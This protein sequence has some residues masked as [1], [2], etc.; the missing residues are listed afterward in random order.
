MNVDLRE[1]PKIQGGEFLTP[2]NAGAP[3]RLTS[4]FGEAIWWVPD[5]LNA[6]VHEL[7]KRPTFAVASSRIG[8][9]P[10]RRPAWF[11]M[12]ERAIEET[13]RQRGVMISVNE[14]AAAT[15]VRHACR[16]FRCET[17]AFDVCS[18]NVSFTDWTASLHKSARD[19]IHVSPPLSGA[20]RQ[21]DQPRR[22]AFAIFVSDRLYIPLVSKNGNISKLVRSRLASDLSAPASVW[23]AIT[24]ENKIAGNLIDLGAVGWMVKTVDGVEASHVESLACDNIFTIEELLQQRDECSAEEDWPYLIHCTRER[25]GAWPSQSET[26]F[27]DEMLLSGKP[28]TR[29]PLASLQRIVDREVIDASQVVTRKDASAVCCFTE[30]PLSEALK[31]RVFR[32]HLQ[33]WDSEPYGVAIHKRLLESMGCRAVIYGDEA[34]YASLNHTERPFFQSEGSAVDWTAEREWRVEGSVSL[35]DIPVENAFV[36][37]PS[38]AE[39]K[40]LQGKSRWPIV[41]AHV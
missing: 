28:P 39:A 14:T 17:L 29:G 5:S 12:L 13:Q 35:R 19:C 15:W 31:S 41:V 26:A 33:R 16:L 7:A 36:F 21:H 34:T 32:P 20:A 37:V 3:Q 25:T 9:H 2:R 27:R 38:F 30:R 40:Q 24:D 1:L 23:V 18:E 10:H 4:L 6:S 11:S 8:K 22:D